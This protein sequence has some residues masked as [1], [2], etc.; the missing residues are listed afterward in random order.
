MK[1]KDLEAGK[2]Y[3][4]S[5]SKGAYA[6]VFENGKTTYHP[7]HGVKVLAVE[8]YEE[9]Q[10]RSKYEERF[11]QVAKGNGVLVEV[12]EFYNDFVR[13]GDRAELKTR[14]F[15]RVIPLSQIIA[16][17]DIAVNQIQA[18]KQRAEERSARRIEEQRRR[19]EYEKHFFAPAINDL[20]KALTKLHERV[21]GTS[22]HYYRSMTLN[23]LPVD[24]VNALTFIIDGAL[25]K[26]EEV[27]A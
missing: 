27:S 1:R 4:V 15:K 3:Y 19:E 24:V 23:D 17:W 12:T 14:T 2:T 26:A 6:D 9:R 8:P 25:V 13:Y 10:W 16:L 18:N 22:K 21:D 5:H 7:Q 20:T 11:Q